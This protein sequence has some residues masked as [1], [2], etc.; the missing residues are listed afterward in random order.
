MAQQIINIGGAPNDGNGDTIR[1]GGDKINDNFTELYEKSI[2][3]AIVVK[4]SS[5]FGVI[6]STKVYIIDWRN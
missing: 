6:D 4:T 1:D 5:D 2:D 3:S